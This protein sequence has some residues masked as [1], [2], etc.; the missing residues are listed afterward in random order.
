MSDKAQGA[1]EYLLVIGAAVL[2]VALAMMVI[3]GGVLQG[4][5]Q[6]TQ[7]RGDNN[8]QMTKLNC[9]KDCNYY[10]PCL[11]TSTGCGQYSDICTISAGNTCLKS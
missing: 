2:I 9:L 1:I 8:T 11:N 6:G 3:S 10:G 5:K 7:A 4:Q